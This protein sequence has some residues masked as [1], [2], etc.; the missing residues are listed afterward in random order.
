[1]TEVLNRKFPEIFWDQPLN[2]TV[3]NMTHWRYKPQ[4]FLRH[5]G[6]VA[7]H[8]LEDAPET[9]LEELIQEGTRALHNFEQ[10][11]QERNAVENSD[12]GYESGAVPMSG[13]D[14]TSFSTPGP[15]IQ[16][17]TNTQGVCTNLMSGSA[18]DD[19]VSS[20][21]TLPFPRA[22]DGTSLMEL[23]DMDWD[24]ILDGWNEEGWN[25]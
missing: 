1:M 14:E 23:L 16:D 22:T 8:A 25:L 4:K 12:S 19:E 10:A 18:N 17:W 11:V 13:E 9:L 7:V 2:D 20:N 6:F 21:G 3:A 15:S 5:K 24:D